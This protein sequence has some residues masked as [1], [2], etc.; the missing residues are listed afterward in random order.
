[1]RTAPE[2]YWPVS[3][4]G[5]RS[6]SRGVPAAT[7]C[8]AQASGA[9]SEI[10]DVIGA[11]DGFGIVL[12]HQHGVAEIAET[13]EG[14][15]Q[16]VIIARMKS[17]GRL[18]QDIQHA[19]K[20]RTDLRGQADALG[21]ATGKRG[22]GTGEAEVIE[23]D[24]GEK[25]EAVANLFDH[26]R[27]DLLLAFVELP[28][29]DGGERAIDGHLGEL[30]DARAFDA[31]R[32]TAGAQT[33]SLAIGAERRRHIVHQPLAIAGAGFFVGFGEDLDDAVE[34]VA[35]FE[36]QGLR[37]L[38]QL[39]ERLV[40]LDAQARGAFAELLLHVGGTGAGAEAAIEQGL[41][42]IDNDLGGIET[43][44]AAQAVTSFAGAE[45][46]VEGK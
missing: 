1:M 2:R 31:H 10:D 7:R 43:P 6:I 33:P 19:A 34:S 12:H 26:A 8:A 5:F 36:Q 15:E 27:G 20:F 30:G 44:G 21:F 39:F 17:D 11:L 35:A 38:G 25:F 23:P 45:R 4:A 42:G 13:G 41:G 22:G 18:V 37:L 16:A 29:F 46:A 40:D 28:G 3:E 14:I 32:Q 24:G 9:G